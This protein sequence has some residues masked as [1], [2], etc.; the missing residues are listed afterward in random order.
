MIEI[1]VEVSKWTDG[2]GFDYTT[3]IDPMEIPS[4]AELEEYAKAFV[5]DW[6]QEEH[7]YPGEDLKFGFYAPDDEEPSETVWA[8]DVK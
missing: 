3:D 8:S 6:A 7:L 1:R 5:A 4:I 2:S